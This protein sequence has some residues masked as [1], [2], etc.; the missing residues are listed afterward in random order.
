MAIAPGQSK[1]K[2]TSIV[3]WSNV[4]VWA[5]RAI[6]PKKFKGQKPYKKCCC[7]C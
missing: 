4:R 6:S 3:E 5:Y 7:E 2:K 1:N